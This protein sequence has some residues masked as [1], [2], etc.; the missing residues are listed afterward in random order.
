MSKFKVYDEDDNFVGEYVGE[1]IDDTKTNVSESFDSSFGLGMFSLLCFVFFKFPWMLVVIVGYYI[2]KGIW[3][4]SKFLGRCIWWLL[5]FVGF[6]LFWISL[7]AIFIILWL[8]QEILYGIWRLLSLPFYLIFHKEAPDW[9]FP[10]LLVP[11]WWCPE[12]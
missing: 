3:T 2:L 9:W 5:K 10:E 6:C 11:D 8:L 4:V 1:F 12:W 7:E